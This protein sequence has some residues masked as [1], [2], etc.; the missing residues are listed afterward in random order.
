VKRSG[1]NELIQVVVHM[2]ME[3]M[4]GIFLYNYSYVELAKMI[5]FIVLLMYSLKQNWRRRQNRFCLE[6]QEVG[7]RRRGQGLG[8]EM[9]QTMYAHMNK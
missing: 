8:G 6:E 7:R 5:S 1:R 4:L 9:A 2:C 3:A